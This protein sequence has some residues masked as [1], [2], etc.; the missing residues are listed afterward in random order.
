MAIVVLLVL[1]ASKIAWLSLGGGEGL[2][3]TPLALIPAAIVL[4]GSPR[5]VEIARGIDWPTL[6]FFAS[7]FVVVAG[8]GQSG[9][10]ERVVEALGD[11]VAQPAVVLA[12]SALLSQVV[13]NVPLVALYLPILHGVEAPEHVLLA[14][15][16]GSTITGNLT[17]LGAASNVIVIDIAERRFG[18]RIGFVEFMRIGVPLTV[19]QLAVYALFLR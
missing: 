19:L 13:S 3:L 15:A 14:L 11:A 10:V 16:A 1:I 18:E 5:R 9:A 8:I 6:A 17:I 12:V 7:L 2:R 4:L